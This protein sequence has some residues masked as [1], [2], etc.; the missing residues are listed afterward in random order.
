MCLWVAV[1]CWMG[2]GLAERAG[3]RWVVEGYCLVWCWGQV[4]WFG[5][6]VSLVVRDSLFFL[7]RWVS[8]W[9]VLDALF[10]IAAVPVWVVRDSL[11]F[12]LRWVPR[13]SICPLVIGNILS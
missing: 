11:C 13:S 10:L 7:L 1:G 6:G 9:V 4:A 5:A 12:L 8:R 2:G 3:C